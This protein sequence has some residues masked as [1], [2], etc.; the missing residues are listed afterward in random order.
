MEMP[1]TRTGDLTPLLRAYSKLD[2][3]KA[4]PPSEVA[5]ISSSRSGSATI[6]EFSMSSEWYSLV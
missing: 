1:D 3:T 6:G 4:A 2:T 5:Q